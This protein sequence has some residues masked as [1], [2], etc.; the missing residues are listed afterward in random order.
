LSQRPVV[1]VGKA[2]SDRNAIETMWI[3]E[4]GSAKNTLSLK[5]V[6]TLRADKKRFGRVLSFERRTEIETVTLEQLTKEYGLPFFI[7][8]DVEGSE[9]RVL[10]GMQ[11]PV[12]YISFEVNLPEFVHEGLQCVQLLGSMATN[13]KFNYV[14]D[15]ERGL[16]LKQWLGS[17]EFSDLLAQCPDPSI[18][19]FWKTVLE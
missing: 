10:R 17:Q 14:V 12:P 6:E 9:L 11:Q 18:E 16:V 13:G 7:K 2:V 15:C 1:V 4:P 5:W 8:I 19:V 3:D